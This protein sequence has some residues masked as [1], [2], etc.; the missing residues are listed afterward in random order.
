M[1]YF[2]PYPDPDPIKLRLAAEILRTRSPIYVRAI[3]TSML[4]TIWPG[5][6]L[7][8]EH[9]ET[10]EIRVGDIIR[11][12]QAGRFVIHRVIVVNDDG[13][14]FSWITRGDSVAQADAPVAGTFFVGRVCAI[15]RGNR[16]FTPPLHLSQTAHCAGRTLRTILF[17]QR[18]VLQIRRWWQERHDGL[19]ALAKS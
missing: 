10:P 7:E 1:S 8:I 15:R 13:G 9:C 14:S 16:S 6:V 12:M 5:D 19:P 11:F 18:G 17:L 3:G 4:P 2:K